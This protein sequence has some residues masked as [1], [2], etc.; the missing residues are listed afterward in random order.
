MFIAG[1]AMASEV[2]LQSTPRPERC[3]KE[4]LATYE[5]VVDVQ[6]ELNR[7]LQPY[8]GQCDG[9]GTLGNTQEEP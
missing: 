2:E 4:M 5:A 3:A 1:L 9:W 7:L 8:G 6:S